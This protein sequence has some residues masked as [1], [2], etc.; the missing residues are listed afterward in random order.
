[1]RSRFTIAFLISD[2]PMQ[3]INPLHVAHPLAESPPSSDDY[4]AALRAMVGQVSVITLQKPNGDWG[5]LTLTSANVLA[6]QPPM[7][8]AC[9]NRAA[10]AHDGLRVG[11][12]LGWQVLGA[13]QAHVA[14]AFSGKDGRSGAARFDGAEWRISHGAR[15]LTGAA[16]ACAAVIETLTDH[17]THTVVTAR[18]LALHRQTSAAGTLAYRDGAYLPLR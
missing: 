2:I 16:L 5:G 11:T 1:M 10:S 3:A 13:D 12:V 8:I 15:L 14:N 6:T 18:I 17:A 7:M 9:I 4:R